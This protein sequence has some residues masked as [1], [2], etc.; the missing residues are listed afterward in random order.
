MRFYGGVPADRSDLHWD[1]ACSIARGDGAAG[2]G[3]PGAGCGCTWPI[4]H[5]SIAIKD[6]RTARTR[7]VSDWSPSDQKVVKGA[8]EWLLRGVGD[9]TRRKMEQGAV[10]LH[11]RRPATEAELAGLATR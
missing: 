6:N 4:W 11:W 3:E 1:H 8:L 9:T 5:L 10:A 2:A 7:L